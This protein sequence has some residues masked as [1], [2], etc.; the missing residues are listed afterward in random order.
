M[1]HV[2]HR[3]PLRTPPTIVKG[4]G[5]YLIDSSGKRYLD[6][7][8]GPAVACLGHSHPK[9]IAA[10]QRQAAEISYAYSLF[11]SSE[12]MEALADLLIEDAP[13]DLDK[14]FFVCGGSEAVEAAMKLARQYFLEIG[15]PKRSRFIARQQSYHGNTL[16]ALALGGNEVRRRP[17]E[18]MLVAQRHIP[19]CYAYREKRPDEGEEAYGRR[20]ADEL[21]SAILDL[22]PETVAA[23]LAEPVVGA[24]LGACP[25]VPG[26]LKRVRDICDRYGVLLI[27][28]E[29][30]CGMG[31]TGTMYACAQ[32]GVA[33]DLLTMAKGLGGGYQPVGGV[34]VSRRIHDAIAKGSGVLRHG[35]TYWGHSL[36]CAAALAV[37][38]TIREDDLLDNVRR[39]GARLQAALRDRLGNHRHVGDIRGRGLMWALE[40]VADRASKAPFDPALRVFERIRRTAMEQGMVCYPSGGNV[41]GVR[42]DN[43]LLAPPYIVTAAEID[44]IA[45]RMGR[46]VDTVIAGLPSRAVE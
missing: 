23:F 21:E 28:D 7:S 26:Y 25:P 36:A 35:H 11:F 29:V 9:V 17:Y 32:D 19:T 12:P 4:D 13:G 5:L 10:I 14:A 34:L 46:A 20:V 8:G 45:D 38:R 27:F 2:F 16:G 42:G 22:G 31:R 41:D 43:V 30:L 40:L 24:T 37:Q 3:E 33:P 44:E 6:A 15:Q 18:P 1:S 39:Q